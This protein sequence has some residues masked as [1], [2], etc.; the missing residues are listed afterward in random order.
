M[1]TQDNPHSLPKNSTRCSLHIGYPIGCLTTLP[2]RTRR[3]AYGHIECQEGIQN[4]KHG[5]VCDSL[6][7]LLTKIFVNNICNHKLQRPEQ[8]ATCERITQAL[9]AQ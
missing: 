2:E 3:H 8:H 4:Q 5:Y 1:T 6:Y 7:G 9:S